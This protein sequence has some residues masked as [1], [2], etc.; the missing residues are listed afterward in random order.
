MA[1]LTKRT[2]EQLR[3]HLSSLSAEELVDVLLAQAA[4]D[5]DLR[6]RLLIDAVKRGADTVDLRSFQR[7]I[8]TA[9]FDLGEGRH[10]A[11]HTSGEWACGVNQ[12]IGRLSELLAAGLTERLVGSASWASR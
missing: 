2:A 11:E 6:D 9:I 10:G 8:N 3:S 4:R 7:S 12:V 5:D 1:R